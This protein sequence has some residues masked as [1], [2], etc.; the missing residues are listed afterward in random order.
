MGESKYTRELLEP[1]VTESYSYAEVIRKLGRKNSG[2]FHRWI[3]ARVIELGI[4]TAHFLG[5]GWSRGKQALNSLDP[6]Q[7]LIKG[8]RPVS[9]TRLKRAYL[10][11]SSAPYACTFCG[12]HSWQ[13]RKLTLHLDHINGDPTDNRFENLRFLCP[14]CHQQTDT[15]GSKNIKQRGPKV[16][17][18]HK[19]QTVKKSNKC[20]KCGKVAARKFCSQNCAKLA[21]RKVNRPSREELDLLVSQLS[22]TALGRKYGVSDNAVRKWAKQYKLL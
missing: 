13:G 8:P 6:A 14:N 2:S 3:K 17:R 10:L 1:L 11:L 19:A 4:P 12:I 16:Q 7:Y 5:Q 18:D 22:F 20:L 9:S 15:W 21:S